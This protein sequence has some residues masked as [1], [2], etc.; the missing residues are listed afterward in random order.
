MLQ[1]LRKLKAASGVRDFCVCNK[2]RI[3][4]AVVYDIIKIYDVFLGCPILS[5]K[6][7]SSPRFIKLA[8][9]GSYFAVHESNNLITLYSTADGSILQK[10]CDVPPSV[11]N[12][13]FSQNS[14]KLIFASTQTLCLWSIRSCAL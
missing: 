1:P 9:N 5:I 4:L 13:R 11:K 6:L 8:P 3:L 2:E 14:Q 12:I 7:D 10:I